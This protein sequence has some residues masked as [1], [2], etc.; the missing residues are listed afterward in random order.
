MD[1]RR[2][3]GNFSTFVIMSVVPDGVP[4]TTRPRGWRVSHAEKLDAKGWV[5]L[6]GWY[7]AIDKHLKKYSDLLTASGFHTTRCVAPTHVTFG[8]TRAGQKEFARNIL[9]SLQYVVANTSSSATML[10]PVSFYCFSNGGAFIYR[11]IIEMLV[12]DA[13]FDAIRRAHRASVF[14]SA[15]CYM[16]ATAGANALTS[17]WRNPVLVGLIKTLFLL[18]AMT[19]VCTDLA[20]EKYW[21]ALKNDPLPAATLYLYSED[22]PLCDSVQLTSLIEERRA[23]SAAKSHHHEQQHQQPAISI[24]SRCWEI[25][26]HVGHLRKHPEEYTRL[27]LDFLDKHMC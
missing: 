14:D 19:I 25:S 22:D 4:A 15:P 13:E 21:A 23:A 9:R 2:R 12:D 24:E 1:P 6:I 17:G 5:V 20:P 10:P 7:G 18:L 11:S 8:L 16:H 27:L 26:E 3:P